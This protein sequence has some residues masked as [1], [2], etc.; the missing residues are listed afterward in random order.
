[1][2]KTDSNQN[3]GID[4]YH[5]QHPSDEEPLEE[6]LKSSINNEILKRFRWA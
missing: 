2:N 4:E 5:E 1:M 6:E 3:Q